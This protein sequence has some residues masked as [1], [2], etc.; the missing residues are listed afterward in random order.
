MVA[1]QIAHDAAAPREFA[2]APQH[3]HRVHFGKVTQR[4]RAKDQIETF[5]RVGQR[6][7]VVLFQFDLR[8]VPAGGAG[9]VED[10][11]IAIH[12]GDG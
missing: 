10:L 4:E 6:P 7:Q 9:E 8:P 2:D 11:R 12:G 5:P 1:P 3:G